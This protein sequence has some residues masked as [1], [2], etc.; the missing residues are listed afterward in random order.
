MP[1]EPAGR[2]A[3]VQVVTTNI[4]IPNGTYNLTNPIVVPPGAVLRGESRDGVVLNWWG[5]FDGIAG[6]GV[7]VNPGDNCVIRDLTI[8]CKAYNGLSNTAYSGLA[9][10]I[11]TWYGQPFEHILVTNIVVN[12]LS[13]AWY[14]RQS[15]VCSGLIAG[16]VFNTVWDDMVTADAL[17]EFAFER[18]RFIA[19]GSDNT[20]GQPPPINGI[21]LIGGRVTLRD[22]FIK[23]FGGA[24]N[25]GLTTVA[26]YQPGYVPGSWLRAENC[27]DFADNPI[28][29]S[30][31]FIETE[32]CS[33]P[34][35]TYLTVSSPAPGQALL[36]W[37]TEAGVHYDIQTSADV[38][39]WHEQMTMNGNDGWL[40]CLDHDTASAKFY[41]VRDNYSPTFA[42]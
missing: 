1:P 38:R 36:G 30:G 9:G 15:N 25:C 31:A 21:T 22:C 23:A 37:W 33:F 11:G 34:A 7:C 27:G 24:R 32:R 35:Q 16:C 26:W 20:T 42:R 8:V 40:S 4:L 19:D 14:V 13:D 10:A 29:E 5:Y 17:H 12:G 41:R 28:V 18:C 6:H 3:L 2:R 39:N